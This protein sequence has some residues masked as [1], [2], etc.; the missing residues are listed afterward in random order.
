MMGL[1]RAGIGR[2][3]CVA[4]AMV[5]AVASVGCAARPIGPGELVAAVRD[6]KPGE[7]IV[8]APGAYGH[9]TL[10]NAGATPAVTIEAR[11]ATFESLTLRNVDGL[12]LLNGTLNGSPQQTNGLLVDGSK[13]VTVKGW[14]ISGPRIGL[15][16]VRSTDLVISSNQF[17]GVRSDGINIA[18]VQ[19]VLIE[20]NNCTDFRPIPAVYDAMGKLITDG[21]H[22]DC[23]QGWSDPRYADT[24]DITITGNKAYGRMQGIFLS[25]ATAPNGVSQGGFERLVIENNDLTLGAYHGIGLA[26]VR[27]AR[28]RNNSV[29]RVPGM[30]N[31]FYPFRYPDPWIVARDSEG[32]EGCGNKVEGL[33]SRKISIGTK[34][35]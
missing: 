13:H 24:A 28:I 8:L 27:G 20:N 17:R 26:A 16:A 1:D 10:Q 31:L 3:L 9:V 29:R 21:D 22:A 14:T 15:T 7:T 11:G 25:S 23:I 4:A 35:C 18:S 12:K 33:P 30:R 32:V 34:P 2:S 6:A 5:G 19:R